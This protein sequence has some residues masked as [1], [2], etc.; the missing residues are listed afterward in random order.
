MIVVINNDV[1]HEF[2]FI[3]KGKGTFHILNQNHNLGFAG[4]QNIG[5]RQGLADKSDYLLVL[6]NDTIVDK[7]FLSELVNAADKHPDGGV[8]GPKIYFAKGH[9]FHSDRY[10][11]TD[12]GK[13]FWYAGGKIDWQNLLLPHRGVDE[14][15]DGQYDRI[16]KTD[17]VSG[18]CMLIR[19]EVLRTVGLFDEN[20]F[21]Y[22]EDSDLN[23]RIKRAGFARYY[24]PDSVIWHENAGSTGGS[25][26][27]LQDYFITR[28]RL[29]FGMRYAS[30][31]TKLA[32]FRESMNLLATGR[33]WQKQGVKDYYLRNFGKGSYRV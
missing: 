24:I 27:D 14:V 32:L 23:E 12:K 13:V 8:F 19:S 21:L 25:G 17:F 10:K 31:R 9:E 22:L 16:E 30:V 15:D 4:G 6:N 2:D 33:K 11:E 26:S 1:E 5:L 28:N 18:C 3:W 29:L 7:D 20:Y